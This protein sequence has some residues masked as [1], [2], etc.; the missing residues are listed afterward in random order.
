[1]WKCYRWLWPRVWRRDVWSLW[2]SVVVYERRCRCNWL[3]VKCHW[4][5]GAPAREQEQLNRAIPG[6][7]EQDL[8]DFRLSVTLISWILFFTSSTHFSSP[9][10][11]LLS[12]SHVLLLAFF[13][14]LFSIF[15]FCCLCFFWLRCL[16]CY[17]YQLFLMIIY[18]VS[19][20]FVIISVYLRRI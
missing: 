10:H 12:S 15:W 2:S 11:F 8:F 19:C 1:M 14:L 6:S 18:V 3:R 4:N 16:H 17:H 7:G 20:K 9:S 13:F 5:V